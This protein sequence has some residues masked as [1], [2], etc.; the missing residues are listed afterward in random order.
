[1]FDYD[2]KLT[3][4]FSAISNLIVLNFLF[5]VTSLPVITIGAS[6]TSVYAGALSIIHGDGGSIS[7]IYFRSWRRNFGRST[8]LWLVSVLVVGVLIMDMF[9][10]KTSPLFTTKL[11]Y[12]FTILCLVS[13]I[14]IVIYLFPI[15]SRFYTTF[16][17]SFKNA[18][19]FI[20][21]Y[22]IDALIIILLT[23][24]PVLVLAFNFEKMFLGFLS[25]FVLIGC[26]LNA[27]IASFVFNKIFRSYESLMPTN[28]ND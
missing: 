15:Q 13:V 11:F 27:Y 7:R 8:L 18:V 20:L 28:T 4:I 26:S 1:M 24:G 23:F 5:V 6:L 2:N 21:G 16:A 12:Y 3:R 9:F 10:F 25:Y 22:P 17:N 19:L 14:T